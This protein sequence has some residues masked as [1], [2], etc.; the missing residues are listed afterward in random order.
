VRV[1][2]RRGADLKVALVDLLPAVATTWRVRGGGGVLVVVARFHAPVAAGA[3]ALV[4]ARYA[5][6]LVLR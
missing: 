4:E 2:L 6:R 1:E 3:T 5:A